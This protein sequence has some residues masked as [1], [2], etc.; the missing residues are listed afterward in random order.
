[1][2]KIMV[3][4][5]HLSSFG[6][7]VMAMTLVVFSELLHV[8]VLWCSFCFF[9]VLNIYVYILSS[10]A[11]L[12]MYLY[13]KLV[14][15]LFGLVFSLAV[16]VSWGSTQTKIILCLWSQLL[17]YCGF[18]RDEIAS[19]LRFCHNCHRVFVAVRCLHQERTVW[20]KYIAEKHYK[21]KDVVVRSW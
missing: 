2:A 12:V 5:R 15:K 20:A 6:Y 16:V 17:Q 18:S 19:S 7:I 10:D 14:C 21:E 3:H 11:F 9:G 4:T 8:E 13:S 1:M